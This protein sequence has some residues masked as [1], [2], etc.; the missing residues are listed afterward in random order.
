MYKY[1]PPDSD[2][3]DGYDGFYFGDDD[4]KPAR[5]VWRVD[6]D[7][8][9]YDAVTNGDI[10]IIKA[11]LR[12]PSADIDRPLRGGNTLLHHACQHGHV[13][14]VKCLLENGA[15][16]N[17][18]VESI[19][20]LMSACSS[21]ADGPVVEDIVKILVDKGAV[22]NVSN[23]HGVTPFMFACIHG[24]LEVV[25]FLI[26]AAFLEATDNQGWTALFHAIENNQ[27]EVVSILVKAGADVNVANRKG[28]APRQVAQFH[29]FYDILDI[30]P[31]EEH[32]YTVPTNYLSYSSLSDHI[33]CLFLKTDVPAYFPDI[34]SILRNARLQR[35]LENFA[36]HK[37]NLN[38][39]L[40]MTDD[41]LSK[42]DISLPLH[43]KQILLALLRYHLEHWS[44]Q[45]IARVKRKDRDS[46]YDILMII[47]NHLKNVVI[48]S[49]SLEYIQQNIEANK[50]GPISSTT[51]KECKETIVKYKKSIRKLQEATKYL[52]SFS[53]ERPPLYIN[54]DET[55]KAE[56][57]ATLHR[58]FNYSLAIGVAIV[59]I[60]KWKRFL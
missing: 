20:P 1:R 26:Q 45:S 3:D 32:Q 35:F 11:H 2:S 14:I 18:Q 33:P 37:I 39:F 5:P 12:Q 13:E 19:T 47:S 24:H 6:S 58:Y 57:K 59:A 21:G 16:P 23:N 22:V 46:F 38:Q 25:A 40:T 42:I 8:N 56:K 34:D 48:I 55:I 44:T 15:D 7:Q 51:I 29:G 43:R 60:L 54:Y 53:P 27:P 31:A 28:Y 9:L 4:I 30:L 17:R 10:E 41:K 50:L 49:S 36:K 52:H